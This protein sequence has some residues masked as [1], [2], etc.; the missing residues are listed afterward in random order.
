MTI[1]QPYPEGGTVNFLSNK[2]IVNNIEVLDRAWS[3]NELLVLCGLG[4]GVDLKK[5]NDAAFCLPERFARRGFA[6]LTSGS[7][8]VPKLVLGQRDRAIALVELLHRVQNSADVKETI[9]ALPLTYVYSFV[10][11]W[12]WAKRFAR[13]LIITC[14]F[15]DP[16]KLFTALDN[17]KDAM[18][19]FVGSQLPMLFKY[20]NGRRF[21][22]IIRLHFAGGRFPAEYMDQLRYSFPNAEIFNNYGCTEAMPRLTVKR[23]ETEIASNLIGAPISGVSFKT[24]EENRLYFNSP[25]ACVAWM[26]NHALHEVDDDEWLATGDL[27]GKVGN[28][29]WVLY[30]RSNEMIKRYGEKLSL[31][32]IS[33]HISKFVEV[34]FNMYVDK[35]AQGEDGYILVLDSTPNLENL[36]L[37]IRAK[38]KRVFWPIRIEVIHDKWPL[39]PNGKIDTVCL[40]SFLNKNVLWRMR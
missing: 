16:L 2:D 14:G 35:D 10:N 7:T 1:F 39:L 38:F 9:V 28:G 40:G 11:Q 23:V 13:K 33:A 29:E 5:V 27:A 4:R 19:C 34:G 31:S 22:R 17:A 6:V 32:E 21:S 24:D 30:G 20:A 18:L 8:G 25:F 3:E 15:S 37:Q 36:L 26:E 12:V